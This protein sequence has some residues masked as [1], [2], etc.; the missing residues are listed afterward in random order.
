MGNILSS[1]GNIDIRAQ[2]EAYN[3]LAK[4]RQSQTEGLQKMLENLIQI[5]KNQKEQAFRQNQIQAQNNAQIAQAWQKQ[6]LMETLAMKDA[7]YSDKEISEKLSQ[8]QQEFYKANGYNTDYKQTLGEKIDQK[9]ESGM[10]KAG[11]WAWNKIKRN[12]DGTGELES[13]QGD[14]QVPADDASKATQAQADTENP[15]KEEAS[16]AQEQAQKRAK[17]IQEQAQ[18]RAQ[19]I[20]EQAQATLNQQN[21]IPTQRE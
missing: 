5:D 6:S 16:K 17:E 8:K 1:L 18:K 10:K 9:I 2:Q 7:G 11:H 21:Q 12:K 15:T 14:I 19:E 3:N 4:A 13:A 20:Q